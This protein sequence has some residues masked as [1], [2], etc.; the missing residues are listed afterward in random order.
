MEDPQGNASTFP[1]WWVIA[2]VVVAA[3]IAGVVLIVRNRRSKQ[4]D[5][6][7]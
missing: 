4:S 7:R 5:E 2:I 3:P 1:I 6:F